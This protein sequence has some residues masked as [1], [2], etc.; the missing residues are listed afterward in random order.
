MDERLRQKILND[1]KISEKNKTKYIQTLNELKDY[2]VFNPDEIMEKLKDV[3]YKEITNKYFPAL[4]TV[5]NDKRY[6]REKIDYESIINNSSLAPTTKKAYIKYIKGLKLRDLNDVERAKYK[7]KN[8][9]AKST[10]MGIYSAL[11]KATNNDVYRQLIIEERTKASATQETKQVCSLDH[12]DILKKYNLVKDL[13]GYLIFTLFVK[14]PNLRVGDYYNLK[15]KDFDSEKGTIRF[16]NLIKSKTVNEVSLKLSEEDRTR[17]TK[18]VKD[19][20]A[21]MFHTGEHT[22]ESFAERLS[23]LTYATFGIKGGASNFRRLIYLK[24][25]DI[26][27]R[28]RCLVNDGL[29]QNHKVDVIAKWYMKDKNF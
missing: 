28:I 13:D 22:T 1:E 26:G 6:T 14:Y 15:W 23:N 21:Y 17:F 20:D 16:H 9:R 29:Q 11:L 4:Y 24:Y 8:S 12:E 2:N 19:D 27:D 25:K 10:A 5:T 7:I 3:P 18:H